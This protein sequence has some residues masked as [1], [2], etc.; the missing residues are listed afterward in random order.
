MTSL[1]F[2]K[3]RGYG[4][5]LQQKVKNQHTRCNDSE[6]KSIK[7]LIAIS[8]NTHPTHL[9]MSL[10]TPHLFAFDSVWN[11]CP[12]SKHSCT[13]HT[14][15]RDRI[16]PS[17]ENLDYMYTRTYI[18]RYCISSRACPLASG[19]SNDRQLAT[20]GN[21][22]RSK[23]LPCFSRFRIK[24]RR[25]NLFYIMQIQSKE[26]PRESLQPTLSQN[27]LNLSIKT[28]LV[29]AGATLY[30]RLLYTNCLLDNLQIFYPAPA[31]LTQ[32]Y[33]STN[34]KII[35]ITIWFISRSMAHIRSGRIRFE[36]PGLLVFGTLRYETNCIR[37]A[38]CK[39]KFDFYI[40]RKFVQKFI[41]NYSAQQTKKVTYSSYCPDL[42]S[43][44][45][46]TDTIL[47]KLFL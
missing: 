45:I 15:S 43:K 1:V 32:Q 28:K 38:I 27:N 23:F 33:P 36:L 4:W 17:P 35:Y 11:W 19:I 42:Y 3:K 30:V 31:P 8:H 25:Q 7:Q 29:P 34:L 46:L 16:L 9:A 6:N 37:G 20:E 13:V 26:N 22:Q 14:H 18:Y 2:S 47:L 41:A 5:I 40:D 44:I 39:C 12:L 10:F 24:K 21:N